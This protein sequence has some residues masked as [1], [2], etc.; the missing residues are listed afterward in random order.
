MS[1]ENEQITLRREKLLALQAAGH[2]PFAVHRYERTHTTADI[3]ALV[4]GIEAQ[5]TAEVDWEAAGIPCRVCGRLMAL[6]DQGK[7]HWADLR[8]GQ[9]KVQL[10]VRQD[11]TEGFA[12]FGELDLGDIIGG[13]GV[14]FRTR[15]GEITVR[16]ER[17][18]LLAKA[19]RPLPDKWHGLQD[20]ETRYRQRYVDLIVNEE[21]RETFRR[22]SR[23]IS[24]LRTYLDGQGFMEVE[25]PVMQPIYGGAAAKPFITHHNALDM[26]LFLRIAPELYLKRLLVGGFERVYEIGRLFRNEGVDT[27]HNPEF[28][29]VETYQAFADYEEVMRQAEQIICAMAQAALGQLQF[30]YRE[31]DIDLTPPWRRLSL[32]DSVREACGVDFAALSSDAEARAACRGLGLEK[33]DEETL[34]GLLDKA[35]EKYVQPNLVQ[36]TFV[37][38]YPVLISPLAKR[39]SPDSPLTARFEIFI[40]GEEVGN[41]FSELNDP[42]DQ[43]ARFEAQVAMR[44]G[45]DEEAHPLDEDYLRA[46]EYGMPPAGGLGI[47]IDRIIMILCGKTSLREVIL[48]PHMRPE[49]GA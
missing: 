2:D 48:F 40:G 1:S 46:L 27:R 32:L 31:Q 4:E 15:R 11:G 38:G 10:W 35:F 24:A 37:T 8:D 19:L 45:G 14:A 18:T 7:S 29:T 30:T 25:T 20:V 21:S 41:A 43:R 36:P 16:L 3:I 34:P 44:A 6:R 49:E 22:R 28:T 23:A 9:G 42:L 33:V 17:Y 39:L 47:G 13:E 26:D 12:E 5:A